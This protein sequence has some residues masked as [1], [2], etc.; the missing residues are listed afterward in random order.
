MLPVIYKFLLN[1]DFSRTMMYVVALGLVVYAAV[2]GWRG[3]AGPVDP[4]TQQLTEPSADD[5]KRR[6]IMFGLFGLGLAAAGLYYA[7]PEVPILGRGKGEGIPIHTYGVLVGGGFIFAV[8]AAGWMSMRE[9]PGAEGLKKRDQIFDLAFYVFIGAMVGSRVLFIIVNWKDYASG[10][11]QILSLSGGLVFY[12]GLIGAAATAYWYAKKHDIEF[13]RLADVAMPTVSLGHALGRQGCFSAGCCWGDIAKEGTKVAVHFPGPTATNLFGTVGG[14]PSLAWQ[15]MS[16][17]SRWVDVATGHV[18]HQATAGSVQ[19]SEWVTQ[20]GHTLPLHPTQ[21]YESIGELS[22]FVFLITMRR[23]RRFHGQIL[24]MWLMCYA[25]LRSSVELFRGDL[26]RGTLNGLLNYLGLNALAQ[27]VPL[28]AWYNISVSQFIS[29]CL[30]SL[31]V[32]ILVTKGRALRA[33][34]TVDLNA[35]ALG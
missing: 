19:I 10:Q 21:L 11:M 4:K 32:T 6:A 12:G 26:E 5:R 27:S 13:L 8:T 25:L 28:E 29:M 30:F 7:L 9:W 15:S 20:H 3:A 35:L 23:Y 2:S 31:G 14:T 22:L 16:T 17:D 1:T 18:T 33:Q 24:G 34:P